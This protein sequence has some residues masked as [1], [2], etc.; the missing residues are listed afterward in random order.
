MAVQSIQR[1]L[2]AVLAADVAG[3]ARL[4]ESDERGTFGR[5]RAHRTEVF[6]PLVGEHRG[7]IVKHTGD[8]AL[9]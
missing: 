7:R 1:R 3:F 9:C 5:L 6:E 4:M 8:G 2:A